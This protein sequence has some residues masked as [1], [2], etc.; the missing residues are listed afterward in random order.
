MMKTI[1]DTVE[2]REKTGQKRNDFIDL[3]IQTKGKGNLLED[4]KD[5]FL[6]IENV[7]PIGE[8]QR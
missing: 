2:N 5:E 1:A 8:I 3:L 7:E 6:N 4:M